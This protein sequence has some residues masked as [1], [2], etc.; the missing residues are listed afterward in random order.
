[1]YLIRMV[2]NFLIVHFGTS[3]SIEIHILHAFIT[4][5]SRTIGLL[6]RLMKYVLKYIDNVT[7]YLE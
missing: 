1:M 6:H 3:M 5:I 2:G 4:G 7:G